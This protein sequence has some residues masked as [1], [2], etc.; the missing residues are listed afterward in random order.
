MAIIETASLPWF[1]AARFSLGLDVSESAFQGFYT[2]NRQ[3]QSTL[4]DRLTGILTLPYSFDPAEQGQREALVFGMRSANDYLRMGLPQR[5]RNVGTLSGSPTVAANVLAGARSVSLSNARAGA[6]LLRSA[7]TVSVWLFNEWTAVNATK[8][9][10]STTDPDGGSTAW[11]LSRTAAGNHYAQATQTIAVTANKTV[12]AYVWIKAGTLTGNVRLRI[13]DGTGVGDIFS[14]AITPTST[15]TAFKVTGTFGSSSAA[16]VNLYIDPE[17]DAG[18]AGD[19]L[20]VWYSEIQVLSGLDTLSQ[21]STYFTDTPSG[22]GRSELNNRTGSGNAFTLWTYATTAHANKTFTFSAWLKAGSF[23]GSLTLGIRDGANVVNLATNT[24]A[25]TGAWQRVSVT[26]T[27]GATPAANIIAYIDQAAGG[28]IGETYSRYGV[29]LEQGSAPTDFYP[30]PTA[31][32]G[33]II[34][35]GGNLLHVGYAGATGDVSGSITLP[36]TLPAPK[37]ITAG[38]AAITEGA[39]CLWEFDDEA[40]Q[41]D[42]EPGDR[43]APIILPLRQVIA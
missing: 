22:I 38:A 23:A 13:R 17:N 16:N 2:G 28:S 5:R 6:N 10:N 25:L 40:P 9:A 27:F 37:A 8:A 36:L 41:F 4:S 20:F 42:Y 1:K 3:R 7:E 12:S 11:T 34:S 39:T 32:A 14:T 18:S 30:W 43:Q 31:A 26:A 29:Q 19:T 15:W 35:V 24:I 21:S 33:D